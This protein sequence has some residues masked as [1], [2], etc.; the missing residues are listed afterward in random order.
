[1][2][3]SFDEAL[4][5]IN[6]ENANIITHDTKLYNDSELLE[7]S[8]DY[9]VDCCSLADFRTE[10][11]HSQEVPTYAYLEEKTV[12][13]GSGD[14]ILPYVV[15]RYFGGKYSFERTDLLYIKNVLI[16][17]AHI[18]IPFLAEGIELKGLV[19]N[20][21]SKKIIPNVSRN[22]ISDAQLQVL[23]YAVGKAIHM[24]ICKEGNLGAEEKSLMQTF[25][26]KC[27]ADKSEYLK[28]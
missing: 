15:E 7:S 23:S 14:K 3:D 19:V 5:K 26:N 11:G 21:V 17:S 9:I 28:D 22:N 13:E 25:I 10:V 16:S 6:Y 27:Y 20:V 24:W 8:S 2:L 18:K 1:V 12:I 4:E